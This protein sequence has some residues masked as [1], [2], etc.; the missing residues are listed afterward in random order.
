MSNSGHPNLT[1]VV[2]QKL[3]NVVA[4]QE[5]QSAEDGLELSVD[6]YLK[7]ADLYHFHKSFEKERKI[8]E[9]FTESENAAI[10]SLQ[11]TYERIERIAKTLHVLNGPI[12]APSND[13]S[14]SEET[15]SLL[16]IESEPEVV[17]MHSHSKVN[18][19][20]ISPMNSPLKES[21]KYLTICAA[22]TG[23]RDDDEV[24]QLSMVLSSFTASS[25][26]KFRVLETYTGTRLT[27]K[28]VPQRL[29]SKFNISKDEHLNRPF[30]RQ[31]IISLFEQA[32]YVVSH[33]NPNVERQMLVTLLPEVVDSEW[34]ST[35]KDIPWRALGFDS[36]SLSKL[37]AGFGRRKPRTT[38]E[39]AKAI[40]LLLQ[41]EEP[42]GSHLYI[43]RV[44]N[45]KP[46]KAIKL[47][48]QMLA[49]HHKM[50]KSKPSYKILI[51]G[52]FV[53]V[54]VLSAGLK[55]LRIV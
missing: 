25:S 40:S 6:N 49:A 21:V 31:R 52:I 28:V 27:K 14:S 12:P 29:L 45:M 46:M 23:R 22:Y 11:D 17:E 51:A 50:N 15:L 20:I 48:K 33:N 30:D 18:L 26:S 44:Q 35:Q 53:S 9:R 41:H 24:V 16:S 8:L 4:N 34:Y 43:E 19:T 47:S 54:L 3:L 10:E 1:A 42:S 7:L 55:Y 36:I 38:L 5:V 39:R 37:A 32:D 2:E 13:R